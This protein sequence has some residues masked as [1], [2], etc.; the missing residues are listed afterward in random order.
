MNHSKPTVDPIPCVRALRAVCGLI[1]SSLII[2]GT[3]QTL[4]GA[5]VE[6]KGGAST[7]AST[8][9][10]FDVP[11]FTSHGKRLEGVLAKEDFFIRLPEHVR[12]VPGS[13][14]QLSFRSS[15]LLL[16][17]VSTM[18]VSVNDV[19]LSS[20][21]LGKTDGD[22]AKLGSTRQV[23]RIP[24]DSA[25][26][27][28]GWN[29][30]SIRCLLQ[31]TYVPCRD[32]DNPA[33]WMDLESD[34]FLRVACQPQALFPEL[35]RFP[36]ALAEPLLMRL[37]RPAGKTASKQNDAVLSILIPSQPTESDLRCFLIASARL[38]QTLYI[39]EESLAAG[40]VGSFVG[41]SKYRNGML[42][43][44]KEDLAKAG[45]PAELA[46]TL[47]N[48]KPGEGCLAELI[49]GTAPER[50]HRW[51]VVCGGDS[52]G[53][54]NAGLAL[55]SSPAIQSV[56]ANPWI[57]KTSPTVPVLYEPIAH[58][59]A[60]PVPLQSQAQGGILLR[61]LFRNRAERT[62]PLPPGYQTAVGSS[63]DLDVSHAGNL[64][65]TSAFDIRLNDALVGSVA[66]TEANANLHREKIV[67]PAGLAGRDPSQLQ[68]S[69]Y[70]DIG[71]VDCGHRNEE[72]AWVSVAGTSTIDLKADAL[73]IEDLCRIDLLLMRDAFL[74]R[75]AVLLP[76]G[77]DWERIE[78]LK[79]IAVF[80]GHKL[81]SMPVLWPQV[82][83]Y[84]PKK[85]PA[86][87][88]VANRS[89]LILGSVFQWS[90]ALPKAM[91]LSV[92][93][94]PDSDSVILRGQ[95]VLVS[96]FDRTMSLAQLLASPWTKGELFASVGGL[97]GYG[98]SSSVAILT[99]DAVI[100]RLCGTVAAVDAKD[101]A[102][103]YDVRSIQQSSLAE[104]I[105]EGLPPGMSL[106]QTEQK[107]AEK[108]ADALD[109]LRNNRILLASV[110]V[111]LLLIFIPQ[112]LASRW[113]NKNSKADKENGSK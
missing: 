70:L 38:A 77:N 62:F 71:T 24:L 104:N 33:A 80:L 14:L 51:I 93:G 15:P 99:K 92:R 34:S 112:R 56:P 113:K 61:G 35:Q 74:R 41:E 85:M 45:L 27:H 82:A 2:S 7:A 32:V 16:P 103:G 111:G 106:E 110:A 40:E 50:Q 72:R 79:S 67:V 86:I 97:N 53:L 57:I 17:D 21:R 9:G 107:K 28:P 96:D 68:L 75:A 29:R 98:G 39:Q 19:L 11:L 65:K 83:T 25:V 102:I 49:I 64:D 6:G 20:A 4:P 60:G 108:M 59:A 105:K 91:L 5:A 18:S 13:E 12:Y 95:K 30:V 101:R 47:G 1:L 46:D 36:D 23:L 90:D 42:I 3:A 54:E 44:T 94:G 109:V 100:D 37:I 52:A 63:L 58:P 89:G 55:G 10:T 76:D 81:P 88:R 84:G 66:L 87:D 73:V 69:S 31:T 26:V 48:L 43:G 78:L 22:S 8:P